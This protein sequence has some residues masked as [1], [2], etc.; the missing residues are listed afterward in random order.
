MKR[1]PKT[2]KRATERVCATRAEFTRLTEQPQFCGRQLFTRREMIVFPIET[3][4]AVRN[5]NR[6]PE[7]G[8]RKNHKNNSG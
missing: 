5:E 1:I 3:K 8:W 6:L 2:Q 4:H 7:N